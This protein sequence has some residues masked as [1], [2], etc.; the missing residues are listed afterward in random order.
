M[1]L[2]QPW[3]LYPKKWVLKGNKIFLNGDI[4]FILLYLVII[5]YKID[6]TPSGAT[7]ESIYLL[8][9]YVLSPS[10]RF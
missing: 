9:K 3:E 1:R 10:K 5:Y 6:I 8:V 2:R 7:G 4:Y